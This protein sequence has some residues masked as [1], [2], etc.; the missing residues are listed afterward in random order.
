MPV[1]EDAQ[2]LGEVDEGGTLAGVDTAQA[3]DCYLGKPAC[4][5]LEDGIDEGG[6]SDA[7][8]SDFGGRHGCE[9]EDL[10]DGVLDALGDVGCSR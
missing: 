4:V 7:D 10:A 2:W 1:G 5:R 6:R 3:D 8:G 9:L